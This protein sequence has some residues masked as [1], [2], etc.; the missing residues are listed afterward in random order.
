[1]WKLKK[2][3]SDF[4][5]FGPFALKFTLVLATLMERLNPEFGEDW[6]TEYEEID[7]YLTPISSKI[8]RFWQ[9]WT[10]LGSDNDRFLHI[11]SANLHQTLDL[12]FPLVS[13][14]P[15]WISKQTDQ[16]KKN[17]FASFSIFT[18]S[19]TSWI[20]QKIFRP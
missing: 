15:V 17:R 20:F 5:S 8:V 11:Q 3:Q 13:L 14:T 10:K 18:I 1:M 16:R 6:P 4:F 9:F 2:K 19:F 12:I 7:H